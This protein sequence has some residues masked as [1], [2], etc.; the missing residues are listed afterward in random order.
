MDLSKEFLKKAANTACYPLEL[1]VYPFVI[2]LCRLLGKENLTETG[3]QALKEG[4]LPQ[5]EGF[6]S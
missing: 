3:K 2:A 5:Y 6:G 1:L 4:W